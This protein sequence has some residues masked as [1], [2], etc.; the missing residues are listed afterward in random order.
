MARIVK[1]EKDTQIQMHPLPF[2]VYIIRST[3]KRDIQTYTYT[4]GS[5]TMMIL[6]ERGN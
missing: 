3:Y 6:Q 4:N 5:P 1:R 2:Q